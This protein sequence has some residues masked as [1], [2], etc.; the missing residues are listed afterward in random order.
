MQHV[1][2]DVRIVEAFF[3]RMCAQTY[4]VHTAMH[5]CM[6]SMYDHRLRNSCMG[7]Q[8]K[9]SRELFVPKFTK[10]GHIHQCY[11]L[12]S[13]IIAMGTLILSAPMKSLYQ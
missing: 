12:A 2:P 1:Y 10:L 11:H 3:V 13:Y 9:F 7:L 8:V 5:A 6:H 4:H